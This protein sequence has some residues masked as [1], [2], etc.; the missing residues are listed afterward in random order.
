[1][2]T[3][4]I[5]QTVIRHLLGIKCSSGSWKVYNEVQSV[6]KSHWLFLLST[7]R[8]WLLTILH[9]YTLGQLTTILCPEY[10]QSLLTVLPAS[11]LASPQS[12][13]NKAVWVMPLCLLKLKSVG[14]ISPSQ[15]ISKKKAKPYMILLFSVFSFISYSF[16]YRLCSSDSAPL[17]QTHQSCTYLRA[18]ALAVPS[19]CDTLPLVIHMAQPLTS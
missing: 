17:L 14:V 18:F 16:F 7:F 13:L 6:S 3:P 8:V 2:F 15:T 1:M 11:A 10:C 12:L 19:A 9:G 4:F 5:Q